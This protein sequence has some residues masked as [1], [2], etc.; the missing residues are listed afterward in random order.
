MTRLA[1]AIALSLAY[2][3]VGQAIG[4][5]ITVTYSEVMP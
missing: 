3:W 1:C 2:A 4:L 5:A